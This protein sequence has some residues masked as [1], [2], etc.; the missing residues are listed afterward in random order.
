[1][2]VAAVGWLRG[3]VD[4]WAIRL[5]AALAGTFTVLL[6][7]HHLR[8]RGRPIAGFVAG[9]MLA[10]AVHFTGTARIGRIDVPLA[11]V[12]TAIMLFSRDWLA[13]TRRLW[14]GARNAAQSVSFAPSQRRAGLRE[15][16]VFSLV[17]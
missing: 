16:P 6:V 13:A 10:G 8:R 11:C 4:A 12:A 3:G 17:P 9:A 2:L 1:W 14:S 5:P 15:R 7:W